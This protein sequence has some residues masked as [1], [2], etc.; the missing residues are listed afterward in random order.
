MRPVVVA[1]RIRKTLRWDVLSAQEEP[2]LRNRDDQFHYANARK[3]K[4]IFFTLDKDFLDDRRFPLHQSPGVYILHAKHDD[5]N[6]I[7]HAIYAASMTLTEAY[8]K[9]P[10]FYV[11]SKVEMTL[12]G[13]RLRY[14]TKDSEV[15]EL[16]S[17]H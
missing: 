5:T 16:F 11:G 12:E 10:E 13:Q 14:I 1:E 3:L 17:P 8:R 7:Y 15:H 6:D 9:I 4:R 2:T